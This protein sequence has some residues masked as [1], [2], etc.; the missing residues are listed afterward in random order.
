MMSKC[1]YYIA[2]RI[3]DNKLQKTIIKLLHPENA[4]KML[5]RLEIYFIGE[6]L[7]SITGRTCDKTPT[8]QMICQIGSKMCKN[9]LA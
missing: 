4:V 3:K 7:T 1:T 5:R 2:I 6:T 9:I 8:L